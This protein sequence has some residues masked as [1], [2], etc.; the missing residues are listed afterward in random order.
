MRTWNRT[1]ILVLAN[2]PFVDW[3][4]RVEPG[5]TDHT[6]EDVRRDSTVYLF[7]DTNNELGLEALLGDV[8]DEIF[9]AELEGW[10]T[11]PAIWPSDRSLE[12]FKRWFTYTYHSM[13]VDLSDDPL[14]VE[15]L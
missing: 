8:F 5:Q 15:E 9:E 7:P 6:L 2:Q 14:V 11:D 13:V 3:L 12:N 1:A 4:N 10:Y